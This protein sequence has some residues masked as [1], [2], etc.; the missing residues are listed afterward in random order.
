MTDEIILLVTDKNIKKDLSQW[1][2]ESF[3]FVHR[4][5]LKTIVKT[6]NHEYFHY[7]VYCR[8]GIKSRPW[9]ILEQV[10]ADAIGYKGICT[11]E[12]A[13]S[14]SFAQLVHFIYDIISDLSEGKFLSFYWRFLFY[15][16]RKL[17][18]KIIGNNI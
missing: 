8:F 12:S 16:N 1:L 10:H 7:L 2:K 14:L 11:T 4:R 5:A 3:A 17:F 9:I 6:M 18:V 13:K 15:L